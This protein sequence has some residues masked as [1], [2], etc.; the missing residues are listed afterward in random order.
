MVRPGGRGQEEF[1]PHLF[2]DG[3]GRYVQLVQYCPRVQHVGIDGVIGLLRDNEHHDGHL[4]T[5]LYQ[6]P[7]K[8]RQGFQ[9]EIVTFI[10]VLI[11]S[12]SEKV[13]RVVEVE[14]VAREKVSKDKLV[15]FLL[16]FEVQILEF[17]NGLEPHHVQP[18]G[19]HQ[20]RN[21]TQ[22]HFTLPSGDIAHGG[23]D[24]GILGGLPLEG[25]L[26]HDAIVQRLVFPIEERKFIVKTFHIL[27]QVPPQHG[28][29][30]REGDRNFDIG[31]AQGGQPAAGHPLVEL[32]GDLG[33][34]GVFG[35]EFCQI[36]PQH[37]AK[38]DSLVDQIFG[39]D[40]RDTLLFPQAILNVV[41]TR[42]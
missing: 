39:I 24:V 19:C 41:Q 40:G 42:H 23:E 17:M 37:F 15:D 26:R 29:V 22:K 8:P 32:H 3:G 2:L 4:R 31:F 28:S 10:T 16:V 34:L 35:G 38:N 20:V 7:I 36:H 14:G 1:F 11:T 30:G 25:G 5:R 6:P 12:R 13:Q 18:I 9:R 33:L 21:S 27:G